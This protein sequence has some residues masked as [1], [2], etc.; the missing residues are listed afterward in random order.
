MADFVVLT[1]TVGEVWQRSIGPYQVAHHCRR[2]GFTT[3]VVDFTEWFRTAELEEAVFKFVNEATLVL[4]V[5]TTFYRDTIE[6]QYVDTDT[7]YMLDNNPITERV[8]NIIDKVKIKYPNI[9]IIAGGASSYLVKD[10]AMFDAVIHGYGEV[11]V[12]NYLKSVRDKKRNLYPQLHNVDNI[13]G[14]VDHFDIETLDHAWTKEDCILKEETLPIEISRGCIF[15][16]SFC[17]YP[18]NGKKKFDYLRDPERVKDELISNYEQFG[19][20]NYF[21]SDDTFNDSTIKLERLHKVFTSLPFKIKFVTYLRVDLLHAHREQI[22]LLYEMG[23]GSAF[24]GIETFNHEAAKSIGKGM[25]PDKIKN[26]LVELYYE[27]WK[28][29]VSFT[30]SLI[31][32]LPGETKETLYN[33]F[34]WM[35]LHPFNDM[36]FPLRLG[37]GTYWKSDFESNYDKYGYT[38]DANGNWDNGIMT[39]EG[40][41][42]IAQ[43]FNDQHFYKKKPPAS[44]FEF[45]LLSHGY[46]LREFKD[47]PVIELPWKSF[48]LQKH[49][50]FREYKKKLM[51]L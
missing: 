19:T 27:K 20:T 36:W 1:H 6:S 41:R 8:A 33:T 39:Y 50:L 21:F 18:L 37:V 23:L 17:S 32:G 35:K 46:K 49:R 9:K 22:D 47:T 28:E 7:R 12:V 26:M 29:E 40:A 45:S 4:G 14:A 16:C 34:E 15:K 31:V 43:E 51:L 38:L 10:N 30:C 24:M 11:A 48:M 25:H 42:S 5:S 13:N 2:H 3:Q 44:W